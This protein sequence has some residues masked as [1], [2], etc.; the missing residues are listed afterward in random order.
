MGAGSPCNTML[1]GRRP[2]FVKSGILI[3]LSVWPQQT[4]TENWGLYP[5]LGRGAG[6]AS[7][8]LSL[9]PRPTSLPSGILIHPAIWPQQIWAENWGR[10]HPFG[11]EEA[12]SPYNTMSPGPSSTC[13]A[14]FILIYP[15]VWPEYTNVTG[16]QTDRQRFDSIGGTVVQT[17]AQKFNKRHDIIS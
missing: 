17:V 3:H 4:W 14:S 6:S 9:G 13:T 12:G 10:L 2:T 7:I 16:R 11:A 8:T 5:F 1:P 15:T